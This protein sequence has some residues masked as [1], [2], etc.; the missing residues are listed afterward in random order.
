MT[1]ETVDDQ[2]IVD[3]EIGEKG[4]GLEASLCLFGYQVSSFDEHSP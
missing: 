3:R 1:Q 2:R 4:P